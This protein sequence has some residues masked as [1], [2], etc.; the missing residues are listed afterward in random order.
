[1]KKISSA[2]NLAVVLACLAWLMAYCAAMI[3]LA[4]PK[5]AA[6]NSPADTIRF[7]E[8]IQGKDAVVKTGL[9]LSVI[10]A[11]IPYILAFRRWKTAKIRYSL[12]LLIC[13]LYLGLAV[14][15]VL[16]T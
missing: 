8:Q 4:D 6:P 9:V 10:S 5:P 12:S 14:Y 15:I 1:M 2:P 11:V 16:T 13:T 3:A 7:Q